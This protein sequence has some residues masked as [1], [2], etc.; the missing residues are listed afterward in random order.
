M[1]SSLSTSNFKECVIPH[2]LA[3]ITKWGKLLPLRY[4]SLKCIHSSI[5]FAALEMTYWR[6]DLLFCIFGLLNIFNCHTSHWFLYVASFKRMFSLRLF[7]IIFT[8]YPIKSGLKIQKWQNKK[9]KKTLPR[10]YFSFFGK[11]SEE[12]EKKFSNQLGDAMLT[13]IYFTI[14]RNCCSQV[15]YGINVYF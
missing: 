15:F 1:V 8:E 6:N 12:N 13:C 7:L 3:L 9:A 10:K 2:I 11:T 5:K 14:F 4:L